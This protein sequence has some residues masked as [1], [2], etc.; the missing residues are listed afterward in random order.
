MARTDIGAA[1][2]REHRTRQLAVRAVALQE[3]GRI[4]P[5]WG[6]GDLRTFDLLVEAT[7]PLIDLRRATS[8]G[9]AA[10]YYTAFRVAEGISG[11]ASARIA[12]VARRD[13]LVTSLYVTGKTQ[14]Q[15][16]LRT[17][18]S[19]QAARQNTFVTMS[20]S[21]TRHILNGGRDTLIL[22]AA[23]DRKARGWQRITGGNACSFCSMLAGRG[24]VYSED[25]ADFQAHDH[26]SCSAEPVYR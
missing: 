2:T 12:D 1:L 20:G 23:S 19:P 6:T 16:S 18:M 21:V 11:T 17:G 8:A 25:T 3:F 26:C 4:W 9:L 10:D 7:I 13:Q 5:L 14:V 24:A 22:S 15:R